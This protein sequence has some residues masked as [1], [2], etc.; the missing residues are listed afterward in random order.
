VTSQAPSGGSDRPIVILACPRSGTTLLSTMLHSHPRIAIPPETRFLISTYL[1]RERF[2]DLRDPANRQRLATWITRPQAKFNDLGIDREKVIQRIVDGPP[3]LGSAY[4]ALFEEFAAKRGKPRW[5]EKRPSYFQWTAT[6]LRLFPDVQF[7]AIIRDPRACVASLV[8]AS[9]WE[10]G[11]ELALSAWLMSDFYLRRYARRAEPGRYFQLKYEDLIMRPREELSALCEFLEED[12]DE[13]ML[14]HTVAAADIVPKRARHHTLTRSQ[15]D[16]SRID[17]WRAALTP[18][19]I[20]LI[21]LVCRRA[22]RR[23][24]YAPSGL[25]VRPSP[26]LVRS[27][28]KV[29]W[30]DQRRHVRALCRDAVLR[31]RE[32]QPLAAIKPGPDGEAVLAQRP[33]PSLAR[34]ALRLAARVWRAR[35]LISARHGSARH[36]S[37]RSALSSAPLRSKSN[38]QEE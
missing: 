10:G 11:F 8:N 34:P 20:G 13:A 12:F 30:A 31:A 18:E 36:V 4:A 1:A 19:Q 32:T 21:E 24:G 22:M 23:N 9:F 2:G 25:G 33:R 14:D 5:G 28:V 3:T 26:A 29:L 35:R 7:V 15:V 38:A 37:A 6:I 17:A 27:F 16:P